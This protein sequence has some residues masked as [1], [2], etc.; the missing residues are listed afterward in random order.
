ML[1]CLEIY[2]YSF[3][4]NAYTS[5]IIKVPLNNMSYLSKL[6]QILLNQKAMFSQCPSLKV[7]LYPKY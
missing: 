2:N 1:L 5:L 7:L 3:K 6:N 4:L